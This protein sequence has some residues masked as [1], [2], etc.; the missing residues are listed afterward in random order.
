MLQGEIIWKLPYGVYYVVEKV[1]LGGG[2]EI[3]SGC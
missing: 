3:S 2:Y 1:V